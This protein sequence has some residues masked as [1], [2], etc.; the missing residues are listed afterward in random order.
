M[1]FEKVIVATLGAEE[2]VAPEAGDEEVKSAAAA[3][4][5]FD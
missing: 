1:A 3:G 5:R 2:I 4:F